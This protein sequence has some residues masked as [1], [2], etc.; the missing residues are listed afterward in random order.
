MFTNGD[1]VNNFDWGLAAG[2]RMRLFL[3]NLPDGRTTLIDVEAPDRATWD[4]L[5]SDAMP[6]I[7]TFAFHP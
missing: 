7:A 1:T 5:I 3:L 2:G 6:V 4:A